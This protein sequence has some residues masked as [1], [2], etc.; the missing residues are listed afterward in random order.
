MKNAKIIGKRKITLDPALLPLSKNLK[1][2]KEQIF[3]DMETEILATIIFLPCIIEEWIAYEHEGRTEMA[4]IIMA[5]V[6]KK[7]CTFP[8]TFKRKLLWIR[9]I[10]H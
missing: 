5:A 8:L 2:I 1:T 9:T 7:K 4:A 3:E 10:E 6:I